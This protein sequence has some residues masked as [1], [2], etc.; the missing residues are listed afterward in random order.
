MGMKMGIGVGMGR[1]RWEGKWRRIAGEAE[2]YEWK[3][4]SSI[5]R[6]ISY[7]TTSSRIRGQ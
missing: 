7:F 1:G 3:F 4:A 2:R 5:A 6:D